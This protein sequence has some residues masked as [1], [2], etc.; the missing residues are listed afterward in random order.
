METLKSVSPLRYHILL[1]DYVYCFPDAFQLVKNAQQPERSMWREVI[2]NAKSRKEIRSEVE[3][4][5]IMDMF[6]FS[7]DGV[8]LQNMILKNEDMKATMLA[9]WD[10]LY[11]L[12][13]KK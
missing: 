10:S 12:L 2:Q 6:I 1:L 3:D 9:M 4:E 11:D 5:R 7:S 13:K 8:G